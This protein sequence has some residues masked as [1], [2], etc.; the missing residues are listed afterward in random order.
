MKQIA[1]L[2][3]GFFVITLVLFLAREPILGAMGSFLVVK[4]ELKKSDVI[5]VLG[6]G[7]NER[8]EEAARLY[9]KGFSGHIIMSGG[10]AEMMK[11]Q[12]VALGVPQE[13]IILEPKAR[14]TYEHPIFVKPIMQA[15]GFRSAIVVSSTYHMRRSA[16]LFNRAFKNNGIELTYHPARESWFKI[17]GWWKNTDSRE[18]VRE[19]YIKMLGSIFGNRVYKA[20]D[21]FINAYLEA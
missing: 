2:I 9:N 10:S 6:G 1:Q 12:T 19:E 13:S 14:H 20:V 18:A 11:R 4:D 17:E 15:R 7:D 3:T 16:I 8:V 5:V 21:N